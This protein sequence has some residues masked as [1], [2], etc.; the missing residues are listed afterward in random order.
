MKPRMLYGVGVDA[1]WTLLEAARA[2]HRGCVYCA[3]S[4]TPCD[5]AQALEPFGVPMENAELLRRLEAWEDGQAAG[6]LIR[7][8][9]AHLRGEAVE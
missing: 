6:P 7:W 5:L 4:E 8:A 9:A 2:R 3:R 1:W